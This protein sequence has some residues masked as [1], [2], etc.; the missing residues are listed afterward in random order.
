MGCVGITEII[1][2]LGL[3]RMQSLRQVRYILRLARRCHLLRVL[4]RITRR[5]KRLGSKNSRRLMIAMVFSRHVIRKPGGDNRR[6]RQADEAHQPS[7]RT[8]MVPSF[9]TP[10]NILSRRIWAIKEP[11]ICYAQVS[12]CAPPFDFTNRA[13]RSSL[14]LPHCI[15][16]SISARAEDHGHA[17]VFI[18]NQTRQV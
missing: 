8:A 6:T 13:Q 1:K 18:K 2:L 10:Q 12:E 3:P 5:V 15:S 7:E 9:Q 16:A 11:H 17:L 4:R 14:L